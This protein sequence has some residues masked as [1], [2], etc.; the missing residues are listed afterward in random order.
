MFSCNTN[1]GFTD[2]FQSCTQMPTKL[3]K[4]GDYMYHYDYLIGAGTY[5]KVYSGVC[6]QN[7]KKV[8]IKVVDL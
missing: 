1:N 4:I 2:F 6:I 3:K 7:K 8:A 5:S